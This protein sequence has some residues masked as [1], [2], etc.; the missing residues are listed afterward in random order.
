MNCVERG[1]KRAFDIV[2]SLLGL[3][4]LSPAILYVYIRLRRQGDGPVIFR[5][6][7]IGLHG[8]P[9]HILKFRT[10]RLDAEQDGVP[11][12]AEKSDN[13]LTPV[14][15]YLREHHL[16]EM[17]QLW[18]VLVGDMSFVGYRPERQHF[19]DQIMKENSDYEQLYQIRPGITSMATI[20]NGYTDTMEKMLIRLQMDLE[21]LQKRSLWID[22]KIIFTTVRLIGYGKKI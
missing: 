22:L 3:I 15:R 7:R 17:P 19:I 10:M 14:G 1:I 16:D 8:R 9:F 20:Y 12:L 5:Q 18:N 6:E 21:Y 11:Q 4:I 2:A 13:R